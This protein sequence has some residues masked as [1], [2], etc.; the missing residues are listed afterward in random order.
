MAGARRTPSSSGKYQG[1]FIDH[2]G[3]KKYFTGSIKR[4]ETLRIARKLEDDHRQIRLG[5]REPKQTHFKH[6]DRSLM[7]T[8]SE[9]LRQDSQRMPRRGNGKGD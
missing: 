2:L 7:D 6:R 5:Y 9:Y 8:V 3:K 4:A 1:F